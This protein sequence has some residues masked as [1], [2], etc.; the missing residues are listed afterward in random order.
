MKDEKDA[1]AVLVHEIS[2]G[3]VEDP[4]VMMA[5]PIYK[6]QQTEAGKWVM[7]KSNP[8]PKWVRDHNPNSWGQ[9]YKIYGYFTPEEVFYWRLKFE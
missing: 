1:V 9:N 8:A 6:W 7:E 4:E 2:M 3:D 5:E